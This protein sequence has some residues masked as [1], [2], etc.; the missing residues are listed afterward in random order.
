MKI[1]IIKLVL[2]I[3]ILTVV[4]TMAKAQSYWSLSGNSN[5]NSS[6]YIGHTGNYQLRFKTNNVTR[7]LID[8]YKTGIGTGSPVSNLHLH[9]EHQTEDIIGI[10]PGPRDVTYNEFAYDNYFRMT[11]HN[12][13]SSELDGFVIMQ[14]GREITLRQYEEALLNIHGYNDKGLSVLTTGTIRVGDDNGIANFSMGAANS[15]DLD[16]GTSFIG[17]NAM[18]SGV[19]WYL[20]G[21][22][23]HNGGAAIWSNVEGD[24]LF[25]NV[26]STSGANRW[27][28]DTAMKNRVN[29]VLKSNGQ[30][31]AKE[32]LVTLTG[33]PDYVFG[34]GYERMS[35]PETE[36]YIKEN[37]HLPGV[38]SAEEVEEKGLSLGE[39]NAK[40]ME[41]VE[42][43]MLHVIELQKQI[44]ELKRGGER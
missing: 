12:T 25:S 19:K 8:E 9:S 4:G 43:L 29:L 24:L 27:V 6:S 38:P 14:Y 7:M 34:E 37:G 10:L 36:A 2:T 23:V 1:N 13:G 31:M 20:K 5:G 16:Y 3:V 42:E 17:F 30:L 22:G 39:M 21:D 35:L 44:D 28:V 11:T 26:A 40:L 32:V 33:W 41:K 15:A 18:R